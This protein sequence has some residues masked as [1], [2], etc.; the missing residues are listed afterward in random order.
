MTEINKNILST[1]AYFDIFSYPLTRVEIFIFLSKKYAQAEFD[2]AL[3]Y[4]VATRLVY[5]FDRFY[6]LKNDRRV[7]T[8]RVNGNERAA[9]MIKI[10]EKVSDILIRFPYVRG[11]AISGSLSKNYADADSDIDFFIIT[12]P[13]RLWIARTLMHFFK[14]LTFLV[15]KQHYFC[16]NYYIDERQLEIAEKNIYTAIEVATLM[17]LQGDT[18]FQQFY[19]DNTWTRNYLPNNFMRLASAKPVQFSLLKRSIET[20]LNNSI[21][22]WIDTQL[23][24]ITSGRWSKKTRLKKKDLKGLVLGLIANKH[25]S[26]P[27][28]VSFQNK[29]ITQYEDKVLQLL[30]ESENSVAY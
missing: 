22:N 26:K 20:L 17:P 10:A 5:Q 30:H 2:E 24:Q 21:G 19:A 6:T 28:P 11:I 29:L 3:K 23:M 1:L 14:K 27:N 9:G 16:M 13:N 8:K 18:C 12:A 7:I 25:C 4:M 15:N